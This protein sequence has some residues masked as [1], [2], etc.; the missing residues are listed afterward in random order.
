MCIRDRYRWSIDAVND[1]TFDFAGTG[2]QV[3]DYLPA[4]THRIRFVARDLCDNDSDPEDLVF[5]VSEECKAPTP[6]CDNGIATVVMPSTGSIE[7]WANDLDEGSF[8]NC[9]DQ[10]D[11]DFLIQKLDENGDPVG[12][13]TSAI[14]LTCADIPNG[15]AET[16]EVRMYVVDEAGNRDFCITYILLQDTPDADMP[17]GV[18]PDSD[19]IPLTG[20]IETEEGNATQFHPVQLIGTDNDGNTGVVLA[21]T[22]TNNEGR[23]AFVAIDGVEYVAPAKN[24]DAANGINTLDLIKIQR[25]IVGLDRL[26]SA[27]KMIAADAD[28]NQSIN[29]L[30]M[31]E[32]NQIILGLRSEFR[33]NTSWRYVSTDETMDMNNPYTFE[34][35]LA[36]TFTDENEVE[37]F[38]AVKVG[39]V[40][41]DA[42]IDPSTI[43][44]RNTLTLVAGASEVEGDVVR[45]PVTAENFVNVAGYQFTLNHAGEFVGIE[46]GALNISAD[47][48]ADFGN[49]TVTTNWYTETEVSYDANTVLFTLVFADQVSD[50]AVTS[51]ITRAEAYMNG[52][53]AGV[54]IAIAT[55]TA[56]AFTL[57][58]NEP[59]PFAEFTMINFD[60][61]TAAAAT[62][63]IMDV[64]GKTVFMKDVDGVAGFNSI[65]VTSN[66]LQGAS[67]VLYYRVDTDEYSATKKMILVK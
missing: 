6:Y 40:N 23:Y 66:E 32:L 14:E 39:D 15:V 16:V 33:S 34:E 27:Y 4:G 20:T 52:S 30:D 49:G 24:D 67:G 65:N 50:L 38:V 57:Y 64:S 21:Q 35:P 13:P 56:A 63:T 43:E 19:D 12:I 46:S 36:F 44:I 26:D 37:D 18:C 42:N 31:V 47:Q 48:V 53:R 61:P 41:G 28:N 25:H 2:S 22:N 62:V 1:G 59:N 3:R 8:D 11:L 51:D 17:E 45:I 58:Q 54:E 55:R 5:T 29:V 10:A 9:T 60:L 7:V